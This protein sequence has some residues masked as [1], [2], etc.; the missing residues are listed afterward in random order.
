MSKF[1]DMIKDFIK[2]QEN[3]LLL[4]IVQG[5]LS[6]KNEYRHLE[7]PL[8]NWSRWTPEQ[9][10]RHIS[11][12]QQCRL[13]QVDAD[14]ETETISSME[15][16]SCTELSTTLLSVGFEDAGI[17]DTANSILQDMWEKAER[18]MTMNH[19]ICEIP[20]HP[21]SRRVTSL[22]NPKSCH[23]VECNTETGHSSCDCYLYK[24]HKICQHVL[25]VTQ[26]LGILCAFISWR[27]SR[28][29]SNY[30]LTSAVNSN[31]PKGAGKKPNE[32]AN[33]ACRKK[34][35]QTSASC[36]VDPLPADTEDFYVF[37]FLKNTK[38][39]VCY[40]CGQKFRHSLTE[41]PEPPNDLVLAR[42]EYRKYVNN[43]GQ[44]KMSL[45]K[46]FVHYHVKQDCVKSKD[47]AFVPHNI[48]VTGNIRSD[49][50]DVHK[51]IIRQNIQ[52]SL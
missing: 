38:I 45:K 47:S 20:D 23:Y 25:A 21:N 7:V 8:D 28:K 16:S 44:L 5:N 2:S 42:K 46:E 51:D 35:A 32:R 4:A 24:L 9:R 36:V 34:T 37:R 30:S 43:Y 39:M 15:T 27:V 10:R 3:Q 19:A 14:D 48:I 33:W 11:K 12:V 26:E 52:L 31:I 1:V 13:V 29:K 22:S 40:G 49:L 41:V 18:L 50:Q 17:T 6:S